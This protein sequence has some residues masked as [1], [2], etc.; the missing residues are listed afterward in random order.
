MNTL[1]AAWQAALAAEHAAVAGYDV[2]GPRLADAA[3]VTLARDSQ[4]AHRELRDA[5][6]AQLTAAGQ[7]PVPAAA[8]YPLPFAV[9]GPLNAQRFAISLESACAVAWRYLISVTDASLRSVRADA[10]QALTDSALRAMRWR[11]L[12]APTEPTVPFP[13]I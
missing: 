4:Q 2:I 13:G 7:S 5:T 8:D 12:V 11:R 10:Q 3:Q 1:L 9:T 6:S